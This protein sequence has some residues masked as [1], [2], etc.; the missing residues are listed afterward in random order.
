MFRLFLSLIL[1]APLFGGG[2]VVLAA[3][4]SATVNL[5]VYTSTIDG[6]GGPVGCPPNCPPT[7]VLG[8]LDPV[9]TNYNPAATQDDG[10]CQYPVVNVSGFNATYA[11]PPDKINLQWTNPAMANFSAV[12]VVRSTTSFPSGPNDGL[13]IYDGSG[14]RVVDTL[15]NPGI[16]YFYTAFV[17]NTSGSYSSGAVARSTI[18][19]IKP[20]DIT[21]VTPDD[22]LEVP[23]LDSDGTPPKAGPGLPLPIPPDPFDIFPEA[24]SPDPLIAALNLGD[25]IF[26]QPGERVLFFGAGSTINLRGDK[27][28]TISIDYDKVPE[29]LKI[30]GLTLQDPD[31]PKKTF[32]VILKLNSAGTAYTA[33]IAPLGKSGAYPVHIAIIDYQN[34]SLKRING[35]LL[36]GSVGNI[37]IIEKVARVVVPG[38]VI[39]SGL[40]ASVFQS[41]TF[42][43]ISSLS[44]LYW[45]FLRLIGLL[46]RAVGLRR[47]QTPWGVVY[48]AVT[49]R[50]L[51][52]AYVIVKQGNDE[53][54]TAITDLDGRYAFYVPPGEYQLAANK[55]HY[56]FPSVKMAGRGSDELYDNLYFGGPV[57]VQAGEVI[58]KNIPLDP[59]AF[60]WNEFAKDKRGFFVL[61]SRREKIKSRLFKFIHGLGLIMTIYN[62]AVYPGAFSVGVFTIYLAIS[63]GSYLWHRRHRAVAVRSASTGLPLAFAIIKVFI[64]KIDQQVKS[65]VADELGRFFILTPPGEYY[66][67][68]EEKQADA[69][70]REVYHSPVLKLEQGILESDLIVP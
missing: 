27:I 42:V 44:D 1:L 54:A 62:V 24:L 38:A 57:S 30:I 58:N 52:P 29:A 18:S 13:L 51:D 49:K 17:R 45:L 11:G 14:E 31:D 66:L 7:P 48:D 22:L 39:A 25:F 4:D 12:R 26:I 15:V 6:G 53:K 63:V 59:V 70:Y 64:P 50:P 65:V 55:T 16:T 61:N 67:T 34:Q 28:T 47:K 60:D 69:T 2:V 46:L 5:G 32:S 3:T 56:Q 23:P 37:T 68:V 21:I 10:T 35:R 41:M 43:N 36:V 9:A 40:L 19:R 8:C 33:T 20:P